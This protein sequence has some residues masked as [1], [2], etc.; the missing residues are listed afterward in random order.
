MNA[1]NSYKNNKYI[2]SR[3]IR[4]AVVHLNLRAGATFPVPDCTVP[5]SMDRTSRCGQTLCFMK[6]EFTLTKG[7]E[8][9]A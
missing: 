8:L 4:A 6:V 5:S 7:A 2:P 1:S 9:R 3:R